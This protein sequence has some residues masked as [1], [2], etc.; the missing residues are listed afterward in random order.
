MYKIIPPRLSNQPSIANCKVFFI[1]LATRPTNI[2]TTIKTKIKDIRGSHFVA[3]TTLCSKYLATTTESF[4]A[5]AKPIII[6]RKEKIPT[7]KPLRK[8][9]KMAMT[10]TK[11]KIISISIL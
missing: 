3:E 4:K 6:A 9:L 10:N 8:P 1:N 11:I 5:A 7:T 2:M